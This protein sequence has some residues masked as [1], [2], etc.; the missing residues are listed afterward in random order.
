LTVSKTGTSLR[1]VGYSSTGIFAVYIGGV[2][3]TRNGDPVPDGH[4]VVIVVHVDDIGHS[5]RAVELVNTLFPLIES[6]IP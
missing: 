2:G 6:R 4:G 1:D 5:S 3:G